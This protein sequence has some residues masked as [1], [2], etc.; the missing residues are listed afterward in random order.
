MREGE[1]FH[2]KRPG[3]AVQEISIERKTF[4]VKLLR[5]GVQLWTPVGSRA[6]R[7]SEPLQRLSARRTG[8][9]AGLAETRRAHLRQAGRS[10]VRDVRSLRGLTRPV[11][12]ETVGECPLG[13]PI[14]D[15][16]FLRFT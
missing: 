6:G 10:H 2:V 13:M 12:R 14:S 4:H 11:S 15:V 16:C 3:R 8:D 9:I 5:L 7:D 1:K